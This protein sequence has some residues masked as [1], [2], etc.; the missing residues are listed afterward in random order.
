[1][2]GDSLFYQRMA[3]T[4]QE[5]TGN[6]DGEDSDGSDVSGGMY[7]MDTSRDSLD[8][9]DMEME[10]DG[11]LANR[12]IAQLRSAI[13]VDFD[14]LHPKKLSIRKRRKRRKIVE[15]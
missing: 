7:M 12:R 1:M 14:D 9:A 2:E 4:D 11:E 8:D 13:L 15:K 5:R 10:M 6:V 3:R